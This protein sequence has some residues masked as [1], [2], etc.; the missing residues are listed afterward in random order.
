MLNKCR[1]EFKIVLYF[2]I[3]MKVL[4]ISPSPSGYKNKGND[5]Y[6]GQGWIASMEAQIKKMPNINLA[7]SFITKEKSSRVVK[8]EVI[9]YPRK[10]P[11]LPYYK[12]ILAYLR[13]GSIKPEKW[14]WPYYEKL[15]MDVV[16]DYKPDIVE[17][18]GSEWRGGVCAS[19]INV[20]VVLHVQ[21]ILLP[22][23]NAFLPPSISLRDYIF[24]KGYHPYNIWRQ[25]LDVKRWERNVMR[26]KY[27]FRNIYNYIGRTEWDK[28]VVS[29]Y[30]N[31]M[32]YFEC[33]ELLRPEFYSEKYRS[34]PKQ[35]TIVSTI[36]S[37]IYKGFD[38]ILKAA[39]LMTYEM[40][41]DFVWNV[42]GNV[43]PSFFERKLNIIHKD[44][45]VHV[46][47]V[48][49]AEQIKE[50][51]LNCTLY[52]HPSYIENSPNSIGEAQILGVPVVAT[53]VGGVS[54]MVDN[55]KSGYLVPSNDPYMMVKYILDIYYDNSKN[56]SM[57]KMAQAIARKRHDPHT[58]TKNLYTI[59]EGLV[60]TI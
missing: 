29:F 30:Q 42:Y 48:A 49:K 47:G 41:I 14:Y 31:R 35:L 24:S 37:P 16:E 58:V 34:I 54:S 12:L 1:L 23:M 25:Y 18:W 33:G 2:N 11:R 53:N 19:K 9:Y 57:G 44:V 4:W 45:N 21:G 5:G 56:V 22:Y 3:I 15:F 28:T 8:N 10:K 59:Y 13:I 60:S 43:N 6:H 40:K 38:V 27:I 52:V 51:L 17:I 46:C 50:A 55:S 36:S 26:E 7:V 20:P 39:K 32:L